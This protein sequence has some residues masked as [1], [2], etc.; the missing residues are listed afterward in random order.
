[1]ADYR[2]SAQ[3]I[4]RSQGRS[5][6]AAAAYRSGGVIADVRTGEVHD[7][8]R[9][10][11][12][13]WTGIMAPETA[14]TWAL[15]REKLWNIVEQKEVRKDAQL[16]REVQLS[17]PHELDFE[18]RKAL[19]RDFVQREFV[20]RGMVADIAMHE[21]DRG[22]DKRNFHAHILL[23]TRE[24]GPDGFGK[25]NRDWNSR[26]ELTA[27]RTAWAEVQNEHLR[28]HLGPQAPQVTHLSYAERGE[29]K[30]ATVHLGPTATGMERRGIE[31]FLGTHNRDAARRNE[32][33]RRSRER[34][35]ELA[36]ASESRVLRKYHHLANEAR[37]ES[38]KALAEKRQA[39]GRLKEVLARKKSIAARPGRSALRAQVLADTKAE[40]RVLK[41]KLAASKDQAQQLKK[42]ARSLSRWVTD[43]AR[44]IWIKIAELHERD[45]LEAALRSAETRLEVR[46]NW[47][48]SSQ[49]KG[50]LEQDRRAPEWRS[51][52]T[53]ERRIRRQVRR[54][55]RHA[56]LA[57][58]VARNAEGLGRVVYGRQG[59]A[60]G[61]ELPN[62]LQNETINLEQVSQRLESSIKQLPAE[63]RA[64]LVKTLGIGRGRAD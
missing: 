14:P 62:R 24:I 47:L 34:I 54:A 26:E 7:Y 41:K 36:A 35:T 2:F 4:A 57:L 44:M 11:G 45:R 23:T 30:V 42:Q 12:V 21:P 49:G 1:M 61:I 19:V 16:A 29:E 15:D 46:Q 5:V 58:S 17:L 6:T 38:G 52:R 43:P 9:K 39:E 33:I 40:I 10:G 13:E 50:W 48:S 27:M 51:V 25:K 3:M 37:L 8:T 63:L 28:R 64:K 22:G 59:I 60:D 53:E 18:Q 32:T 56:A 55:E 20:G 31:T